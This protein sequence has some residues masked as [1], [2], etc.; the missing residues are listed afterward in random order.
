MLT[1]VVLLGAPNPNA[2]GL[3]TP[4]GAALPS[5]PACAAE[6]RFGGRRP[7]LDAGE[8]PKLRRRRKGVGDAD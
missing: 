8:V 5:P 4:I 2:S 6:A 7:G 3:R 1:R